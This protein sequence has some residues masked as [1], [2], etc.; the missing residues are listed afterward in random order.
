MFHVAAL[1]EEDHL[2]VREQL[3]DGYEYSM[4]KGFNNDMTNKPVGESD[5]NL[6]G[7]GWYQFWRQ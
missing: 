4:L 3:V 7:V 6:G 1:T 2:V 5:R